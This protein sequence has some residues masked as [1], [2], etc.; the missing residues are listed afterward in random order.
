MEACLQSL[1][2]LR[3]AN[4]EVIVVDDGSMDGTLEI[5]RRFPFRVIHRQENQG[6][7]NRAQRRHRGRDGRIRRVHRF[8]LRGRFRLAHLFDRG[9]GSPWLGCRRR[10][11]LAAARRS[12]VPPAWPWRRGGRRT[13]WSTTRSA[14]HIPGC[15]MAFRSVPRCA[16]SS[17]STRSSP[18]PA[19]T[20]T[21]AGDCR[22]AICRSASARRRWSWH[23]RRNTVGAYLRQQRGYGK[24]EA[25]LYF[26]HPYRF[27]MLGQ[28]RWLG[29]IYGDSPSGSVVASAR[30]LLR[31]LR[32]G[33]VPDA[34]RTAELAAVVPAVHPRVGGGFLVSV[35]VRDRVRP[36]HPAVVHPAGDLVD[37]GRRAGLVSQVDPR[38]DD[39]QSRLL[40]AL[41]IY[42]GPLLRSYERYKWRLRG[43]ADVE[44]ARFAEPRQRP[45]GW[46]A[47]EFRGRLLDRSRRRERGPDPGADG[48]LAPAQVPHRRR[49]RLE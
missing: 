12:R 48:L 23:F 21:S 42:L 20:S 35:P 44:P 22:I 25:L 33:P 10:P 47:R 30:H 24:A 46:F 38:Y 13:C 43:L 34:L 3:Y 7:S 16:R 17:A 41:L 36:L 28:S 14:E 40:L 31:D 49:S 45:D 27:N 5:A 26:K 4:F 18:R 32:A 11:E 1:L 29:R 9:H 37:G 19:T 15:N 8:G 39:A 6:L 2:Q